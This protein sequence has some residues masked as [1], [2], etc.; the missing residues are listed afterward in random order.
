MNKH[1][2]VFDMAMFLLFAAIL[3]SFLCSLYF[4]HRRTRCINPLLRDYF[5][6]GM[7]PPVLF[8]L[9]RIHDF[10]TEILKLRGGTGEF[11]GPWFTK[12]NY[13]ITC[14]SLN[15]QH[16]LCKTKNLFGERLGLC[17]NEDGGCCYSEEV[18]FQSVGR[19][20]SNSNTFHCS[21]HE[22]RIAHKTWRLW[23]L[24][25]TVVHRNE[26]FCHLCSLNVQHTL[27]KNFDNYVKGHDFRDIF[28]PFG[29]GFV[30]ADYETWKYIRTLLHSLMKQPRLKAFVDQTVQKK[31]LTSLLPILDHAQQLGRVVDLQDVLLRFTFDN[32]FLTTVGHDPKCLSIDFPVVAVG[33]AFRVSEKSIFYR[34]TVPKT[35][36]KFQRWLQIGQEKKMTEACRTI[37]EFIYSFIESKREELGKCTEDEMNEAPS[38]LLTALMTEHGGR[39]H[40]D[41]FVRDFAFN[42]LVAGRGSMASALTWF[43]WLL[44]KHPIVEAKILEE[45]RDNFKANEKKNDDCGHGFDEEYHNLHDQEQY[46]K[47]SGKVLGMEEVKKLVYLHAAL[48]ESLRLFPPLPIQRKQAVKADTL[49]S[50]H[51]VNANTM[52]MLSFYAMGRCEEIWGKDCLEFKPERWISEKGEIVNVASYK[53]IAFNAG[54]RTC[55]GKESSLLQMKM[56]TAAMFWKYR[57]QVVEGHVVSPSRSFGLSMK[58]GLKVRIMKRELC[59]SYN[60]RK[61]KQRKKKGD[62]NI[63]KVAAAILRKYCFK[64][65]EGHVATPTHS[66]VLL[67]KN[68]LKARI[69]KRDV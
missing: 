7:L 14:D 64:V 57:F 1:F 40:D 9:W 6:L 41:K 53:F 29:D 17:S 35:V 16:M 3:A 15:V 69:M 63:Y 55:L 34:H 30:T 4:F 31:I 43:F 12:M 54:P 66:I 2:L 8:N 11:K 21:S 45:I 58:N 67:M 59:Q 61:S 24:Q 25:R 52:I 47:V 49:P 37:D 32:I 10:I 56:L 60:S 44:I 13:L 51:R 5:I 20:C 42:F 62:K 18:L 38:D 36:W 23:V 68:G 39:E 33:K 46:L 19:S 48:C 26:L 22:E 28:E 27:C 65:V 50:G